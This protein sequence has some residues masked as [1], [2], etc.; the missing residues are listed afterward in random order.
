MIEKDEGDDQGADIHIIRI[1]H[2]RDHH[3][4]HGRDH[5]ENRRIRDDTKNHEEVIHPQNPDHP[6]IH[7]RDQGLIVVLG[8]DLY[9]NH[10]H[11]LHRKD[12][13]ILHRNRHHHQR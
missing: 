4:V 11:D 10:D 5:A 3:H 8:H 2:G 13:L 7:D 9:P 6:L 1:I 12:R